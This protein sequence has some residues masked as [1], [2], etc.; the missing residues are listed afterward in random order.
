MSAMALIDGGA[1]ESGLHPSLYRKLK[2]VGDLEVGGCTPLLELGDGQ[3]TIKTFGT[4][5]VSVNI[6]DLKTTFTHK[7]IVAPYGTAVVLGRDFFQNHGF[8][9]DYVADKLVY[10]GVAS[11]T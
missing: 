4:V 1:T 5:D 8:T 9:Q 7:M 3:S 6:H 10:T 11:T 2:S